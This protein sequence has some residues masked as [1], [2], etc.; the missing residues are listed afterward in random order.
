MSDQYTEDFGHRIAKQANT[1]IKRVRK[2]YEPWGTH[3]YYMIP[4]YSVGENIKIIQRSWD[5]ISFGK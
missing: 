3:Q 2:K 1:L 4:Y 5:G